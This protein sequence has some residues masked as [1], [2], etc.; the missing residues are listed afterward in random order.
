[1]KFAGHEIKFVADLFKKEAYVFSKRS[2]CL[3]GKMLK[4]FLSDA[5]LLQ[6]FVFT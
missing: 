5:I 2:L 1:M 4:F 3:V 6:L